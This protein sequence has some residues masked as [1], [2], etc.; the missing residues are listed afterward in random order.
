ML[1]PEVETLLADG[2]VLTFGKVVGAGSYHVSPVTVRMELLTGFSF[3]PSANRALTSSHPS[4]PILEVRPRK[5]SS[6][7]YGLISAAIIESD[8]P[9]SSSCISVSSD[10]A[11]STS[12]QESD[13]EDEHACLPA[14]LWDGQ[15]KTSV[16]IPAFRSFIREM[17]HNSVLPAMSD[18]PDELLED[19]PGSPPSADIVI[20]PSPA[21]I[22]EPSSKSRS[23]SPIDLVMSPPSQAQ[24]S[25]PA[26]IGAWPAS[27]PE[28]PRHSSLEVEAEQSEVPLAPELDPQPGPVPAQST[29]C[30][31]RISPPSPPSILPDF[32]QCLHAQTPFF[33][34]SGPFSNSIAS[35]F[36]LPSIPPPL[37]PSLPHRMPPFHPLDKAVTERV[38]SEI[39]GPFKSVEACVVRR[40]VNWLLMGLLQD[41][42]N[43]MQEAVSDLKS[44]QIATEEDVVDLQSHVEMLEPDSERLL[45]RITG[46]ERNIATLSTLQGQMIVL[47]NQVTT[48]RAKVDAPEPKPV[49]T[50]LDDIKVCADALNNLVSGVSHSFL[51]LDH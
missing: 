29:P 48:L 28:S 36:G 5:L 34:G 2:D 12:D 27:R 35:D 23:H 49:E 50:R 38:K 43:V 40:S 44:R 25:E 15:G 51:L 1:Q 24:H 11:S 19:T 10:A 30:Q 31:T 37:P 33:L 39:K 7:R 45:C 13:V 16:K 18:V 20:H 3:E 41:R 9:K 47:Q 42:I 6:G 46:A 32:V 14:A 8:S 26:V 4:S 17:C 22:L 21:L